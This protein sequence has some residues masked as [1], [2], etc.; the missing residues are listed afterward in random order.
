M[1]QKRRTKR[2][3]YIVEA[4]VIVPVFI[5]AVLM[6]IAIVPAMAT[7]ENTVFSAVD[8]LRLESI[9]AAFRKNPAAVPVLLKQR[10]YAENSRASAF[11]VRSFR[12]LYKTKEMEDLLS[13]DFRLS[14]DET[15]PFAFCST[16][17]FDGRI[18]GRAFTGKLHRIPP[19][20]SGI[21]EDKTVY[22][23]P[24]WGKRYHGGQCTYVK[25]NCRLVY[26][27]QETERAY[28]PC[29]RCDASSARIGTPVF[30]FTASGRAYHM[31]DCRLVDKYYTEIAKSDAVEKGYTP[32]S[33]CGG[34]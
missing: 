20:R 9:K 28:K 7:C 26:L 2:G 1:G 27:S 8:E 34:G 31:S 33:K 3:S 22:I 6:L 24:E 4:A 23:F 16:V 14:I 15:N 11:Q 21:D 19:G 30:C 25:A 17:V 10:V 32:C 5:V 18:T 29:K 13:L 12:Y